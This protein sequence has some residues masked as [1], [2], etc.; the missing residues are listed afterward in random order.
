MASSLFC[1]PSHPES[2]GIDSGEIGATLRHQ[3]ELLPM[4]LLGMDSAEQSC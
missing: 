3:E 4:A 2:M 1:G